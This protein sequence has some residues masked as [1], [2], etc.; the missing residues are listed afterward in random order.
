MLDE[1]EKLNTKISLIHFQLAS[2]CGHK[3]YFFVE[4]GDKNTFTYLIYEIIKS[5]HQ[6]CINCNGTPPSWK[7]AGRST[8]HSSQGSQTVIRHNIINKHKCT[9]TVDDDG[10]SLLL[11]DS[12]FA[13]S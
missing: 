1:L 13:L 3:L 11:S 7:L 10:G 9:V 2:K 12:C 4:I 5:S 8:V 6:G